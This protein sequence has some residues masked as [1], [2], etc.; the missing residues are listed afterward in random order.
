[1]TGKE[2]TLQFR[3]LDGSLEKLSQSGVTAKTSFDVK[4]GTYLIRQVVRDSEG[5]QLSALN[6]TVEIPF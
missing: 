1:M 4:P 5:A 2:K 3:L 6:R